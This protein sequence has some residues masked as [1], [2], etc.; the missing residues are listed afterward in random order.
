MSLVS[1]VVVNWNTRDTTV[2]CLQA[3]QRN[4]ECPYELI[5]VDNGSTDGSV[6]VLRAYED[7]RT[8]FLSLPE[9]LGFAGGSNKGIEIASGDAVCLLNSDTLPTRGWL[10]ELMSVRSEKGAGLVGP[11][12]DHAKKPQRRKPWFGRW[13][14][15]FLP[16]TQL[17]ML[18]FFC[19]LI[20]RE[21]LDQVGLLDERFGLGTFEDDD[22]CRRARDAGLTLWVAGRSW[23]WHEAHATFKANRLDDRAE[24]ERNRGIFEEKWK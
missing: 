24:Q 6:E 14:P 7:D 3:V 13:P 20:G 12:T 19:V 2:A 17:E 21:V 22:Y 4:T 10:T 5:I 23:V 8:R 16:T 1:I 11:Y 9:N 18:S 15:W